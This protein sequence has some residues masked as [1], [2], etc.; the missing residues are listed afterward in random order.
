MPIA[1]YNNRKPLDVT[2]KSGTPQVVLVQP[3]RIRDGNQGKTGTGDI[4]ID[5]SNVSS[6][7]DIGIYA[8][9]DS[10]MDYCFE[11]FDASA[12]EALV[13]VYGI[14]ARDGTEHVQVAYGN[15]PG[16]NSKSASTVFDNDANLFL[17]YYAGNGATDLQ[18][19][20][21]GTVYGP[22]SISALVDGGWDFE[23]ANGDIVDMPNDLAI[24]DGSTDF[25]IMGWINAESFYGD[26][27]IIFWSSAG[28]RWIKLQFGEKQDIDVI[29]LRG[30]LGGSWEDWL[31]G[32]A[33]YTGMWYHIVAT[34]DPTDG[35]ELWVNAVSEATSTNTGTWGSAD[36][37]SG[38]A[39]QGGGAEEFDG[40]M[41]DFR[42][43]QFG[44]KIYDSEV[45]AIE[46]ATRTTQE[47]WDQKAVVNATITPATVAGAGQIPAP[48]P[49]NQRE[50]SVSTLWSKNTESF[51][52]SGSEISAKSA[53]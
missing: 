27:P 5:F 34:Y 23:E 38:L 14:F 37:D 4:E 45:D 13:W 20:N 3:I 32:P 18:G 26:G 25:T 51:V 29:H 41:D 50:P 47:F 46:E 2:Y 21:D 19:T 22:D 53:T 49:V 11:H 36:Q 9:D 31:V 6:E 7:A 30:N 16:D 15:G 42:I 40:M 52:L 12:G 39:T 33:L 43:Y 8:Y 1:D 28:E 10:L 35:M 17:Q 48:A 24:F 44:R